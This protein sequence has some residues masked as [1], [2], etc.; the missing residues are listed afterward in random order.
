M[1]RN[2]LA[3]PVTVVGGTSDCTCTLIEDLPLTLPP[4]GTGQASIRFTAPPGRGEF[5][6]HARLWTDADGRRTIPLTVVGRSTGP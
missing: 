2:L 1:L 6:H 3:K 4:G 5:I